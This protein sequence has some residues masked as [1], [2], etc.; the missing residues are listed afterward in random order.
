MKLVKH[1]SKIKAFTIIEMAIVI[2]VIGALVVGVLGSSALIKRFKISTAQNLTISSPIN[3]ISDSVL[4]L[5]SSLERSFKD[6]ES[7]DSS[8]LSSWYDV[9]NAVDK[10]NAVQANQGN[11]P[12][13]SNSINGIQAVKFDGVND[14]FTVDGSVLNNTNYTIFVLEQRDSGKS[15][16][17]FIGDSTSPNNSTS[18]R[19][20]VL[21]YSVDGTVVHGHS[22][23]NSY[24]SFLTSYAESVGKA[25]IFT[26]VHDRSSGKKTYINGILAGVSEDVSSLSGMTDLAI[27]KSYAGQI[28]EVVV[29]AR[30]LSKDERES[31]EDYLGKKWNV[32]IL[33]D[34]GSSVLGSSCVGGKVSDSGCQISCSVPSITGITASTVPDGSGFLTCDSAG[35]YSGS[36]SYSCSNGAFSHSGACSCAL[37]FEMNGTQCQAVECSF[38]GVSGITNGTKVAVGSGTQACNASASYY[39]SVNYTCTV[40]GGSPT[41]NSGSCY[42]MCSGGTITHPAGTTDTVHTFTTSGTL[43]CSTAG[44]KT[45]IALVVAGGGGGGGGE[46]RSGAAGGGAGGVLYNASLS[47]ASSS[48]AVTVGNGG[49]GGTGGSSGTGGTGANSSIGTLAV[50]VGGSGGVGPNFYSG[51]SSNGGSTGGVC[52]ATPGTPTSGQ[53]N[54]GGYGAPGSGPNYGCGGGGGAGAVGGDGSGTTG[55]K[56]GNG[57]QYNITGTNTYYGGGG[58]GGGNVYNNGYCPDP[59]GGNC[60]GFGSGGLGGGGSLTVPNGGANTGGGGAGGAYATASGGSGGSGIVIIRYSQ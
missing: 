43:D 35:N 2:L 16:N 13:Y 8:T 59:V 49:T 29:F 24:D 18:N 58:G 25:K 9:R 20:L 45:V 36:V 55:A 26:F 17:Y 57:V 51:N 19:N 54:R 48:Y 28:G 10:N 44:A 56:G 3:S 32:T 12:T 30:A 27:G 60:P 11:Y 5:E 34:V 22:S 42:S 23:D 6:S 40:N 14:Y 7:S 38:S 46:Y 21:G 52:R 33:R 47:V 37:G 50:A 31:V 4:W 41:I 39:G 53:G 15:E 1:S